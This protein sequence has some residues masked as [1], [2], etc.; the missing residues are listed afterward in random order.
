[1][2]LRRRVRD[3]LGRHRRRRTY[4][5]SV[6]QVACRPRTTR[7]LSPLKR[8]HVDRRHVSNRRPASP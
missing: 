4:A 3:L 5:G 6:P 1:L 8:I 7:G 2:W